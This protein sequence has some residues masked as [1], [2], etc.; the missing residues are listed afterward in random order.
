MSRTHDPTRLILFW[1]LGVDSSPQSARYKIAVKET[2]PHVP[3]DTIEAS[4][5]T[6]T[7]T[8]YADDDHL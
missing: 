7:S 3:Y 6:R 2:V 8:S 5:V 1:R 4:S